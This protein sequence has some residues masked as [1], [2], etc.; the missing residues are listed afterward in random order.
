MDRRILENLIVGL[1]RSGAQRWTDRELAE[2]T[3]ES[4]ADVQAVID[5]LVG[6]GLVIQVGQG[7]RRV[8][9]SDPMG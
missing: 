3:G 9:P 2:E 4:L 5:R 7:T 8:L 6:S 1:V